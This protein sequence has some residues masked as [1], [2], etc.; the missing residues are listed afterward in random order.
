MATEKH[1]AWMATLNRISDGTRTEL[2]G[3]GKYEPLLD[4]RK[5]VRPMQ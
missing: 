5:I 3:L 2:K 4:N 1:D